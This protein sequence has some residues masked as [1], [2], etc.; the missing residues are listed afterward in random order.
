MTSYSQTT[1]V[2]LRRGTTAQIAGNPPV[3]AEP[4]FDTTEQRM[5]VGST[6]DIIQQWK[7][8]YLSAN[9]D[10]TG[11]ATRTL[12][13]KLNDFVSV[14]D[15]GAVG[16]GIAS[17]TTAINS[18]ET[19]AYSVGAVL[20]F[21]EGDYNYLGSFVSRVS[22]FGNGATI[23][24]VRTD[25]TTDATAG[26]IRLDGTGLYCMNMSVNSN[27]KCAGFSIDGESNCKFIG[28]KAFNCVF[29][30]FNCYN[31]QTCSYENCYANDIRY[32]NAGVAADGFY[33][34]GGQD[35]LV[36]SSMVENF[37][38]I[39][40][41]SEGNGAAKSSNISFINCIAKNANNCDNSATEYNA[42][43]WLENTNSGT[44][45]NFHGY[46]LSG[47]AGQ[48]SG[49]VYG[50]L[51]VGG[52]NNANGQFVFE[53]I[54]IEGGATRLPLGAYM[55]GSQTFANVSLTNIY[56]K[57]A[58]SGLSINAGLGNVI[59]KNVIGEDIVGTSGSQGLIAVTNNAANLYYLEID[60]VKQIAS[61]YFTG[62]ATINF[63]QAPTN[64]T[65]VLRNCGNSTETITHAMRG[66][67]VKATIENVRGY[68]ASDI[69]AGILAS[70][71]ILNNCKISYF[72]Q[73]G[74]ATVRFNSCNIT[75]YALLSVT[76]DVIVNSST[77]DYPSG[78]SQ[79]F[80]VNRTTGNARPSVWF[81]N[82]EIFKDIFTDDYAIRIQEEGTPK[83]YIIYFNCTFYNKGAATAAKTF[84]WNVRASTPQTYSGG[85]SDNNVTYL[86]KDNA[87]LGNPSTGDLKLLFH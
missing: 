18:A 63:F 34:G 23:L 33:F 12:Q 76:G 27:F 56:I 87:T 2:R 28:C 79:Y 37:R 40:F 75:G 80:E 70:E 15:F 3:E 55:G 71:T 77:L 25:V 8:K 7:A 14:K 13:S 4:F 53:N 41:V 16:N 85:I 45:K 67:I 60:N 29:A 39:G 11:S 38:R 6:G 81:K 10:Q 82:C 22:I 17:D 66:Q 52:G 32:E 86:L 26:T 5:G 44:V 69:Y 1:Q 24:Q 49:R 9:I 54:L 65:Y 64:C 51:M 59:I 48:T 20:Y 84:I 50:C 68:F 30:G 47:N 42:A 35:N 57:S 31:G 61:S 74:I 43:F 46:E 72:I 83:P 58:Q 62:G 21:P 78:A 73:S 36:F 19:Y